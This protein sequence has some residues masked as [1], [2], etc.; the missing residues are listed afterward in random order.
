M[1]LLHLSD[2]HSQHRSLTDLPPADVIIHSGDVSFAGKGEEVMDFIDW[3]GGLDYKYK[4]FIAGN[5]DFCLDGKAK[6]RIQQLLPRNCFYLNASGVEIEGVR[7]WG[8]PYF[9][10]GELCIE[11]YYA[12][13]DSI[14]CDT[15][16]LITHRPPLDILDRSGNIHYGCLDLLQKVLEIK[17]KYHLFGHIHDAYGIQQSAD[18]TFS[19]ASVLDGKYLLANKPVELEV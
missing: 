17:P 5:H 1:R 8:I 10:S 7:F 11:K 19:N 2:T 15:D 6:E 12:A 14:P 16:I 18:T 9:L 13:L 3:F 4:I